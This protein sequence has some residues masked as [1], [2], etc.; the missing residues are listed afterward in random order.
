MRVVKADVFLGQQEVM[1]RHLARDAQPVAP[2]LPHCR[3]GRSSG[4]VRH[5]QM[6]MRLAQL[7][8]Q[9]NVAL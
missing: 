5:M 8:H 2:R 7:G 9:A 3:Y 1:R 6:R 4:R